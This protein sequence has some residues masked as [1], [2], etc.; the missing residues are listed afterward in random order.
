MLY[1]LESNRVQREE[2]IG[3]NEKTERGYGKKKK[4][5]LF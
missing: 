2:R 4:K 5:E 3:K 1:L